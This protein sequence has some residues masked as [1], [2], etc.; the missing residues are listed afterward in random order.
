MSGIDP[1][2]D[3]CDCPGAGGIRLVGFRD[4]NDLCGRLVNVTSPDRAAEVGDG[5]AVS[6]CVQDADSRLIQLNSRS[7]FGEDGSSVQLEIQH[8]RVGLD[9]LDHLRRDQ[10]IRGGDKKDTAPRPV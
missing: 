6:K 3:V 7:D 9:G 10:V 8:R 4:T 2:I 5:G 1:R